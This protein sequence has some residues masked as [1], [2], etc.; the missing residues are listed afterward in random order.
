MNPD[1]LKTLFTIIG[2]PVILLFTVLLV[3]LGLVGVYHTLALITTEVVAGSA[4]A[5][6]SFLAIKL[7]GL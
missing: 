6:A 3:S 2:A 5:L 1:V 7:E 4:I